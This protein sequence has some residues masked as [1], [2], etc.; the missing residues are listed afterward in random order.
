MH[1]PTF[2]FSSPT[3]RSKNLKND[4]NVHKHSFNQH[5]GKQNKDCI[6]K[7]GSF[8]K[9]KVPLGRQD[10]VEGFP[11]CPLEFLKDWLKLFLC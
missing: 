10:T 8:S 11:L 7:E 6:V 9:L 3:G 5:P 2:D 4:N 1:A